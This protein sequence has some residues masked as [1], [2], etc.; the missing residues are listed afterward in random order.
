MLQT[1][2]L[3]N[4]LFFVHPKLVMSYFIILGAFIPALLTAQNRVQIVEAD[5]IVGTTINGKR[6]QKILG[7]V[8]LRT[9]EMDMYA[10]RAFKYPD[11]DLVEAFGNIEIDT[12]NEIIWAD[13][14]IYYTDI[15][16]SKL[17][18]R[19][20]IESNNT[21]L[22]G[23]AVDYRF[24]NSVAHFLD[25]IR[26]ED[27]SGTLVANSGFYF[28]R[29]D[30]A[31][32]RGQVQ[33][34]DSL[35]YIEGD[36]LFTNR[37]SEYYELHNNV[38]AYDAE[39]STMLSGDYL[40][41][42]STGQSVIIGQAWLKNFQE[43]TAAAEPALPADSLT[44]L[45]ADSLNPE[46]GD[47]LISVPNFFSNGTEQSSQ[48]DTTHIQAH[49]I[50]SIQN[51][52]P[53]D[54]TTIIKAYED[55]R[56]WSPGF[57]SVSDSARYKNKTDI[58]ELWL[59]AKIWYDQIQLSGPYIWVKLEGG[60]IKK[61]ISHPNPFVV[62]QDT[63][64]NRL[65]QIKGDTL[66]AFFEEGTLRQIEVYPNSHLLRF[67]QQNGQADG[68]IEMTAPKTF[69]FFKNGKLVELKSLGA[70]N[71]VSGYYRPQ[72]EQTASKK[73]TGFS[74]NPELRPQRPEKQMKRRFPPI[75]EEPP[76][77]LPKRYLEYISKKEN[78]EVR[79]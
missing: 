18:G 61:L 39:N 56:I 3:K 53:A 68:A 48:P 66:K 60:D 5:S 55:V 11:S 17:R 77:E 26:L 6:V 20:I 34:Q 7:N 31:T 32:F 72:S 62:R 52:M 13:T 15:D 74:W 10:D 8:H 71:V 9:R 76:F 2:N 40:E 47:S 19:V 64:I 14:L 49:K 36:R 67:T 50:I 59:S 65:N 27:P 54:T 1:V 22:F 43:D 4:G 33:L 58:F 42:D 78:K 25:R 12:G 46:Q 51:R 41:S 23:N 45:P 73:L 30:S 29:A 21:S 69:I 79:E 75:P 63:A 70:D 37:E 24:T 44:P 28:R 16:F 57:S 38:F 35:Q